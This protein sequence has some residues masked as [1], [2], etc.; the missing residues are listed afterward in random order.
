MYE[1]YYQENPPPASYVDL[2]PLEELPDT[3]N[4]ESGF[5]NSM[6]D[7][8]LQPQ[9]PSLPEQPQNHTPT[10]RPAAEQAPRQVNPAPSNNGVDG[11]DSAA[12]ILNPSGF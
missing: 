4:A 12:R 11:S 10:D 2:T 7:N 1:Y 5:P 9:P 3:Y 6:T 8:P